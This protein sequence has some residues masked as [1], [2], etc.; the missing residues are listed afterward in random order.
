M[1]A[2]QQVN[3]FINK[4]APLVQKYAKENGFEILYLTTDLHSENPVDNVVT[5]YEE[6]FSKLGKNI[7]KLIAREIL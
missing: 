6:K 4:V 7:N 1:A 2:E 3:E 5:E